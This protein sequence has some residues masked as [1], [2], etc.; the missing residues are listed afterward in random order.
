[1]TLTLGLC[2]RLCFSLAKVIVCAVNQALIDRVHM[3]QQSHLVMGRLS[4]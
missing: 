3:M 2:E 4:S 1:M